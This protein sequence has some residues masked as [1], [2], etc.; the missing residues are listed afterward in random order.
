[1]DDAYVTK[2]LDHGAAGYVLKATP[3]DQL[4][5][6][7]HAVH[8]GAVLISPQVAN[9]LLRNRTGRGTATPSEQ[10]N[11]PL[12]EHS[13]LRFLSPREIDVLR[14]IGDGCDNTLIAK[15]LTI[16]E[17]TVKNHV[18]V[19]YSKLNIHDRIRVMKLASNLK[20]YLRR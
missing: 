5:V 10:V 11:H 7:I 4:I 1:E 9:R 15:K 14:L 8:N 16:A 3:P 17:Q 19:I 18:S 20:D 2:A 12:E 13:L 6:S